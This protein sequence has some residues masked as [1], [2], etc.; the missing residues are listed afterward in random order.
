METRHGVFAAGADNR[1]Q[2]KTDEDGCGHVERGVVQSLRGAWGFAGD[3]R[4]D[5]VFGRGK[6][7]ARVGG[8]HSV[9]KGVSRVHP[10]P[11]RGGDRACVPPREFRLE[12]PPCGGGEGVA[13]RVAGFQPVGEVPEGLAGVVAAAGALPGKVAEALDGGL[14]VEDGPCGGDAGSFGGGGGYAGFV[15]RRGFPPSRGR[16]GP[17][18]EASREA[19][20]GRLGGDGAGFRGVDPP[21]LPPVQCGVECAEAAEARRG[22]EEELLF[23]ARNR[24]VL[25]GER[26]VA[27]VREGKPTRRRRGE[28]AQREAGKPRRLRGDERMKGTVLAFLLRDLRE[29]GEELEE[30]WARFQV[31][32]FGEVVE[33]RLQELEEGAKWREKKGPLTEF[34][35]FVALD[36]AFF[37]LNFAWNCRNASI[38]RIR[39][40]ADGDFGRW[41]RFPAEA[42][43]RDLRPVAGRG[44]TREASCRAIRATAVQ[45]ALLQWVVRKLDGL[46]GVVERAMG[47]EGVLDE[48]EFA[49]R[50]HG[51]YAGLNRF[52]RNVRGRAPGGRAVNSEKRKVKNGRTMNH[53]N[54][55][56][57]G[58]PQRTQRD[59][60]K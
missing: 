28:G 23:P 38:E 31:L 4:G 18:A 53:M 51:V 32:A 40:C 43:F 46:C 14:G 11:F 59:T 56:K 54:H 16:F 1:V 3:V 26:D 13:V 34:G 35:V 5:G 55:V 15:D 50:L 25:A 7:V 49:R 47:G 24:P 45:A 21:V 48:A 41:G 29:A 12:L 33:A 39:A 20:G 42:A 57:N 58:E 27:E 44:R 36:H 60:K 8:A 22:E 10:E 2:E 37:H 9:E 52:W 19:A 17:H 30:L 6:D